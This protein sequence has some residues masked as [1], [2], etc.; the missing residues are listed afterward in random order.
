MRLRKRFVALIALA[1]V[2]L[3]VFVS[4]RKDSYFHAG[5]SDSF[6]GSMN[7]YTSDTDPADSA[8]V[9]G[10]FAE[11][12]DNYQ[13]GM[14]VSDPVGELTSLAVLI[15]SG[16]LLGCGSI[17]EI[18]D[19]TVTVITALHVIA[20]EGD[21]SVIFPDGAMLR[22][23]VLKKDPSKDYCF[24][25]MVTGSEAVKS[26]GIEGVSGSAAP[27]NKTPGLT[28]ISLADSLPRAGQTVFMALPFSSESDTIGTVGLIPGSLPDSVYVGTMINPKV[29]SQDFGVDVILCSIGVAEGMSGGGLFDEKGE[30][31]GLLLGG[32]DD[33]AG[34]F[35]P[36]GAIVR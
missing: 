14:D 18:A 24:L 8:E 5:G 19:D 10:F 23:E 6:T 16:D 2:F 31:L 30:Y 7:K 22:A 21:I 12:V 26:Q 36:A 15:E 25:K 20:D 33:S 29:Y 1:A 3:F 4:V 17:W 32:N 34:V 35:L 11:S 27:Q 9:D 28:S 13:A